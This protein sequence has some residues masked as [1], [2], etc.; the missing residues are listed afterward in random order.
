MADL[1]YKHSFYT[2][3]LIRFLDAVLRKKKFSEILNN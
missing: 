3:R 1:Q 2:F